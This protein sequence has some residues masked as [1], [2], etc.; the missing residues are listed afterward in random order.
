MLRQGRVSLLVVPFGSWSR[1][2]G[3]ACGTGAHDVDT[4]VNTRGPTCLWLRNDG[5]CN[6]ALALELKQQQIF[7]AR[8]WSV[9]PELELQPQTRWAVLCR[10]AFG[11][12]KWGPRQ[13]LM[14]CNSQTR[15][16]PHYPALHASPSLTCREISTPGALT[17]YTPNTTTASACR[18]SSHGRRRSGLAGAPSQGPPPPPLRRPCALCLPLACRATL[19]AG[20]PLRGVWEAGDHVDPRCRLATRHAHAPRTRAGSWRCCCRSRS[21]PCGCCQTSESTT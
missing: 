10:A 9:R 3:N 21:A 17:P 1:S 4:F 7:T 12:K 6:A 15:G 5:S 14:R 18:S 19:P 13:T 16:C 8:A 20:L 11:V 2:A